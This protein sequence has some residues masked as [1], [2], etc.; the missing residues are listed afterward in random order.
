MNIEQIKSLIRPN[1]L[2]LVPY[3]SARS[4]F[5][6]KSEIF[7]DAN[8]NPFENEFNRYPD[9][10]QLQLKEK[11]AHWRGVTADHLVLG[12]GSDE[13][14]DLIIRIFCNPGKDSIVTFNPSYGMYKVCA[15]INDVKIR[16]FN[17]DEDFKFKKT[18]LYRFFKKSD[19]VLFICNPNNPTGNDIKPDDIL[20]ISKKF[21]GIMVVDEAYIDFSKEPSTLN[22]LDKI[23]QL[24]V[25]QTLSKAVGLAG[26]RIGLGWMHPELTAIFNYVKP[27]YN[28]SIL[29]QHEAFK[30]LSDLQKI[31]AELR[32][33]I[34]QRAY[35]KSNLLKFNYIYKVYPS[36]A[37][38]LLVKCRNADRLYQYFIQNGIVVRNRSSQ[39]GC[40]QC[41]RITV[42]TPEENQK[43]ID[44]LPDFGLL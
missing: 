6:E 17:L 41:L 13:I 42:G 23:P 14:I 37:N 24:I 35:L 21:D 29:S 31:E 10:L 5:K 32:I 15:D 20:S 3:S 4:E 25:L 39:Y 43:L 19:K 11:I 2:K 12:N 8:E 33:I 16:T 22:I 9:P 40:E 7:L 34:D 26:L 27:P 30:R 44:L 28:I 38:F 18:D 36:D 1:I